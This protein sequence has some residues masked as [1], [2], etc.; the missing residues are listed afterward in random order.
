MAF[1]LPVTE[2]DSPSPGPRLRGF[3]DV[4]DWIGDEALAR[5]S[6]SGSQ[7]RPGEEVLALSAYVL[8]GTKTALTSPGYVDGVTTTQYLR[9]EFSTGEVTRAEAESRTR[10]AFDAAT[11]LAVTT[12]WID[13]ATTVA[14]AEV[15]SVLVAVSCLERALATVTRSAGVILAPEAAAAYLNDINIDETTPRGHRVTYSPGATPT[16]ER[17]DVTA[18]PTELTLYGMA[19]PFGVRTPPMVTSSNAGDDIDF[20]LNSLFVTVEATWSLNV[21]AHITDASPTAQ[22]FSVTVDLGGGS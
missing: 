11:E 1:D 21:V 8:D 3:L 12:A 17:S 10:A 20:E 7:S 22:M 6:L 15:D 13:G 2:L 19:Q 16:A 9:R 14:L 18:A 4:V 5:R